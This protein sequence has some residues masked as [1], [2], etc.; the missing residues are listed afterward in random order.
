MSVQPSSSTPSTPIL[1]DETD[2]NLF[3]DT[4]ASNTLYQSR[5]ADSLFED[6][7][8][9]GCRKCIQCSSIIKTQKKSK[10][11]LINH[12]KSKH[13]IIWAAAQA[14][15]IS[16]DTEVAKKLWFYCQNETD[17]E[18]MKTISDQK[19]KQ[20]RITFLQYQATLPPPPSTEL[21]SQNRIFK[22]FRIEI[23]AD[24]IKSYLY[25]CSG[26]HPDDEPLPWWKSNARRYPVLALMAKDYLAI[27]ATSAASERAFS[28]AGLLITDRRTRLAN[29]TVRASCL[30]QSWMEN[31]LLS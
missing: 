21:Q 11:S 22:K 27:P 30:L 1:I 9:P 10:G 28:R 15:L 12:Y 14:A 8:T 7:I 26:A 23:A 13:A 17:D 18:A 4:P 5:L 20:L 3:L 6:E 24:E 19:E 29:R 16:G 31:D 2:S 25:D